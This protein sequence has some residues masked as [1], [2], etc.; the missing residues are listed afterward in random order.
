MVSG[1]KQRIRIPWIDIAKGILIICLVYGHHKLFAIQSGY[2]DCVTEL[3]HHSMRLYAAF[4]MQTFFIITGLCSTFSISFSKF[5]WKNIK[6]LIIPAAILVIISSYTLDIFFASRLSLNHFAELLSWGNQ[7][8]P[9]F[10]LA[11]FWAKILYWPLQFCNIKTQ[12]IVAAVLYLAGIALNQWN[13]FPNYM[14]HRHTLL[15]M[16]YLTLGVIMRN[17]MPF[18]EKHLN[19]LAIIGFAALLLQTVSCWLFGTPFP[20]HDYNIGVSFK[21]FPIHI[22]NV[23]LGTCFIFWLSKAIDKC[24]FLQTM[25]KGTL[26]VYL[27]DG[28]VENISLSLC[29]QLYNQDSIASCI[30]FHCA[31]FAL[32][33]AIFYML[34]KIIYSSK[35]L[36]WIVGKW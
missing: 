26:I 2:E 8:G 22:V 19:K 36:S 10:I 6:T 18:L 25:G 32:S 29:S 17:H 30:L 31:S 9:W 13:F 34:I 21:S 4:F 7:R 14:Y 35:Y 28:T 24:S 27:L 16:P 3:I 11:L 20:T 12:L 5:L 15:M 33:I 1:C 23:L